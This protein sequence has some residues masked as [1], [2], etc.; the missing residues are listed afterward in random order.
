MKKRQPIQHAVAALLLIYTGYDHLQHGLHVALPI[1]EIVAGTVLIGFVIAERV[2]RHG[3]EGGVAWVEFAGAGM[4]FVEAI[5][6]L[7][8]KHHRS[9]YALSFV[10]PTILLLF[11]IFDAQINAMR[12]LKADDERFEM[13]TRIFWW[14]SV[15][16]RDVTSWT[17]DEKSIEMKLRN[18]GTKHFRFGGIE[19][20]ETAMEWAAAQFARRVSATNEVPGRDRDADQR[21]QHEVLVPGE[22]R[23]D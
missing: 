1:A 15:S 20:R 16:W 4:M 10:A 18:G 22:R 8:E 11:A 9:F 14:R 23:A 12:R 7:D 2:R 21:E 3:K 6:K 13:R 17:R 5:A 19:N